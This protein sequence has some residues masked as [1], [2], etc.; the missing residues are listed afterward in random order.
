[1]KSFFSSAAMLALAASV[2]SYDISTPSDEDGSVWA[3][4]SGQEGSSVARR[5]TNR[6]SKRQT[7]WNPPSALVTPLK[8][9][10]DHQVATYS[11]GLYGFKNFGWDQL[12]AADG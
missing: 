11:Q 1:M 8:Q 7:G 2:A 6:P 4:L 12:M 10:W 3:A 5:V 9:V